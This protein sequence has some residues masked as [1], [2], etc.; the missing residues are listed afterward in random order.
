MGGTDNEN[1]QDIMRAKN[2]PGPSSIPEWPQPRGY[3][4]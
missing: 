2:K 4:N 3:K 1:V